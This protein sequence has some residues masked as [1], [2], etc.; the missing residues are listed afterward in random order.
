MNS[1]IVYHKCLYKTN[2]GSQCSFNSF[3]FHEMVTQSFSFN[4]IP[5]IFSYY[6]HLYFRWT[7][8]KPYLSISISVSDNVLPVR[9]L[10]KLFVLFCRPSCI[11][12]STI[13]P[14]S[15]LFCCSFTLVNKKNKSDTR[16]RF[17]L[18][19]QMMKSIFP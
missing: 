15:F 9:L 13:K 12:S 3:P 8:F 1:N 10:I 17:M 19:Y 14:S 7:C 11:F 2:K 5:D 6:D 4:L 16:G 18:V